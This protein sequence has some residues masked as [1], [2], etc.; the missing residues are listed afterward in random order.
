MYSDLESKL[1][2]TEKPKQGKLWI[3]KVQMIISPDEN[4]KRSTMWD[5]V[6]SSKSTDLTSNSLYA[7]NVIYAIGT[8]T[9][10]DR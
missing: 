6:L 2:C 10:C 4:C 7:M 5:K 1:E 9:P 3:R 8:M